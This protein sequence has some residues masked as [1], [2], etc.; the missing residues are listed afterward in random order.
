MTKIITLAPSTAIINNSSVDLQ[1]SENISETE[2]EN[3]KTAKANQ[4]RRFSSS[5]CHFSISIRLFRFGHDKLKKVLCTFGTLEMIVRRI[6]S[7]SKINIELYYEWTMSNV[8]LFM[9]KLHRMISMVI[10]L[11]LV[12]IKL[13]MH[14]YSSL[15]H[16]S[17]I[18]LHF[19]R[20]TTCKFVQLFFLWKIS[21]SSSTDVHKCYLHNITFITLG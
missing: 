7:Q 16:W 15:I 12:I 17:N 21:S 1:V 9:S 19:V 2:N 20:K 8:R 13:V 10:E 6:V 18:R 4:V 11:I 3:W 14:L 5:I